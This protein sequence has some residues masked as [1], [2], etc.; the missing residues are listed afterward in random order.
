MDGM[1]KAFLLIIQRRS[2]IADF[3]KLLRGK[4]CQI[5][6]SFNIVVNDTTCKWETCLTAMHS[7]CVKFAE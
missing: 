1:L 3:K 5:D 6:T 4:A 7:L 2:N